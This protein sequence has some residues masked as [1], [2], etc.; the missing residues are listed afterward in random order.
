M[1]THRRPSLPRTAP[2]APGYQQPE[3]ATPLGHGFNIMSTNGSPADTGQS[4]PSRRTRQ[5]GDGCS[6]QDHLHASRG[7]RDT[8]ELSARLLWCSS[9]TTRCGLWVGKG[10]TIPVLPLGLVRA[11]WGDP[12]DKPTAAAAAPG[13]LER[14]LLE[15]GGV[16]AS[17]AWQRAA[18]A[19]QGQGE[20]VLRL[21][22]PHT[23]T[24]QREQRGAGAPA[25]LDHAGAAPAL[26]QSNTTLCCSPSHSNGDLSTA[27]GGLGCASGSICQHRGAGR[28]A[29]GSGMPEHCPLSDAA[30][31]CVH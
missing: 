5:D 28:G 10:V 21:G 13:W 20:E 17:G 11:R 7:R 25:S 22:M 26:P 14:A 2:P 29:G 31:S 9:T 3:A 1:A 16:Q 27:G 18:T 19:A 8:E 30:A 12:G 23:D 4:P 6:L 15:H 24:R